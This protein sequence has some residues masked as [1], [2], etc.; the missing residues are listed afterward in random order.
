MKKVEV[1]DIVE[2]QILILEL[3]CKINN[4]LEALPVDNRR[5]GFIIFLLGDPHLLESEI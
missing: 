4:C 2:Q 5:I 3:F 1:D